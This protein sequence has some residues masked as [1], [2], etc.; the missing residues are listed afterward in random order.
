MDI[1]SLITASV[2]ILFFFF[3]LI[4]FWRKGRGSGAGMFIITYGATDS[5]YNEEKKKAIEMIADQNAHK[6]MDEQKSG[7]PKEKSVKK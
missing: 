3:F 4:Q 6:K 2:V 1:V 7:E 5:F